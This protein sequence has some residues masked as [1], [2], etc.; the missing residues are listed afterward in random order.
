MANGYLNG[1]AAAAAAASVSTATLKGK[2]LTF[3]RMWQVDRASTFTPMALAISFCMV[4]YVPQFNP[5]GLFSF[6]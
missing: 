3:N 1:A 6:L 5:L 2:N 4:G